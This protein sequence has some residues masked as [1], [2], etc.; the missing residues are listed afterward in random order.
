MEEEEAAVDSGQT[1]ATVAQT[2]QENRVAQNLS[3]EDI[4][5]RTRVPMRHLI[6]LENGDYDAMP[7]ATYSLGFA[8]S[9][10]RALGLDEAALADQLREELSVQ[11][12]TT[13]H[14]APEIFSPADPVHVPPKMFAWGAVAVLALLLV[15]YMAFRAYTTGMIDMPGETT[16]TES[17][18]AAD[19]AADP[20][21]TPAATD[22]PA[23]N[24]PVVLTANDAVWVRIYDETG[25]TL[26]E[27]AMAKG[28]SFTVPADAKGPMILTGRPQAI[29]VTIGG[30]AV[31]P[32]GEAEKTISDVKIAAADLLARTAPA[33]T[34]TPSPA[35][36]KGE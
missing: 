36:A 8:R 22:V 28:D 29:D 30:K 34:S 11:D 17:V 25:G 33:S 10:A 20:A 24:A 31:A 18:A 1:V 19:N 9:Y 13:R 3:L 7:G 21:T 6:S 12:R 32:L 14:Y 4:A 26:Y 23:A 27:K 2:L 15:G 5:A 35:P 16:V